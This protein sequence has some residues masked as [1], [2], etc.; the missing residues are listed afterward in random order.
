[1]TR[2][3]TSRFSPAER[4]NWGYWDGVA[5]RER[6]S[7]PERSRAGTVSRHPFNSRTA[8]PFGLGGTARHIPTRSA[9]AAYRIGEWVPRPDLCLG[10]DLEPF[11][12]LASRATTIA[13]C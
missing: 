2:Y 1:V 10:I 5:A 6:G 9:A 11:C 4:R 8:K 13:F 12:T 3:A 7:L